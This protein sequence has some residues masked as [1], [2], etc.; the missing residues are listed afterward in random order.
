VGFDSVS[1]YT[2]LFKKNVGVT[3]AAFKQQQNQRNSEISTNPLRFIPNCFA[4]THGWVKN[5][6]F[7][8]ES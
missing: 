7:E 5:S 8:E 4:E 6:N 1:T 3:P 2:G